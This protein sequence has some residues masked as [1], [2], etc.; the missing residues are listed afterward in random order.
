MISVLLGPIFEEGVQEYSGFQYYMVL[1]AGLYHL[2]PRLK[3][4]Y[5]CR[6]QVQ[7]VKLEGRRESGGSSHN[8]T[9]NLKR[10]PEPTVKGS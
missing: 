6:A 7:D 5:Q 9:W 1:L 4:L 3:G 8:R 2:A 10:V